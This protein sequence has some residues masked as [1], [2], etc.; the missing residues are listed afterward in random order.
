MHKQITTGK[1]G[2]EKGPFGYGVDYV[3][4]LVCPC[5]RWAHQTKIK[6]RIRWPEMFCT[7]AFL[8]LLGLHAG[9]FG[10]QQRFFSWIFLYSIALGFRSSS[11]HSFMSISSSSLCYDFFQVDFILS[12]SNTTLNSSLLIWGRR[13]FIDRS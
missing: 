8:L 7:F 9:Y 11:A 12:L 13:E 5:C 3:C 10:A 6:K 1:E 4:E 2:K